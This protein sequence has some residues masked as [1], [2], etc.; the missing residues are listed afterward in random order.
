MLEKIILHE[1]CERNHR[2]L[3]REGVGHNISPCL[4]RQIE[5]ETENCWKRLTR[6][7]AIRSSSK[8]TVGKEVQGK[9]GTKA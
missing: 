7:E 3:R 4:L 8:E 5:E 9:Q 1:D 6:D 2:L